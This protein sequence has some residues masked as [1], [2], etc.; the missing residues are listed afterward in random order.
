MSLV[1][2]P[3]CEPDYEPDYEIVFATYVEIPL[4]DH[5]N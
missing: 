2:P 4:V 1:V 5:K 3:V